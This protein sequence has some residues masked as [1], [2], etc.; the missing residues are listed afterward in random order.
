MCDAVVMTF[1]VGIYLV[2]GPIIPSGLLDGLV[3][4]GVRGDIALL[5]IPDAD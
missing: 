4:V 5:K 1:G 2:R 3:C